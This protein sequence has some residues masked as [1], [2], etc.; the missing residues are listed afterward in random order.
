M[1][2]NQI[3][4]V[5]CD[6]LVLSLLGLTFFGLHKQ[7]PF[8]RGFFCDDQSL[9]HPYK[10]EKVSTFLCGVIWVLASLLII[11]P[12]EVSRNSSL[13]WLSV[14]PF[15]ADLYQVVGHMAL[16]GLVNL[17]V[18]EVAKMFVGRLRP[19]FLSLCHPDPDCPKD[20]FQTNTYFCQFSYYSNSNSNYTDSDL[21]FEEQVEDKLDE[22][23]SRMREARLSFMSGHA[24]SSFYTAIFL[25]LY[26]QVR[27][28]DLGAKGSEETSTGIGRIG[29]KA[30][31]PL[32]QVNQIQYKKSHHQRHQAFLLCLAFGV[33][34][35]RI[36]DYYHH[37]LDVAAGAFM[38]AFL[39]SITFYQS[40]LYSCP[41]IQEREISDT[42]VIPKR[43]L[44]KNIHLRMRSEVKAKN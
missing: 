20:V 44:T 42:K 31:K 30:F 25:I 40:K 12:T 11:L 17:L 28:G 29:L 7:D 32:L 35:T 22:T 24:A 14:K 23:M 3:Y 26:L 5:V 41:Q 43:Y 18:T 2:R 19:H 27:V 37:P 39:A 21:Q 1:S 10:E 16:G 6:V 8:Q 36:S 34:Y 38:G 13:C 15:A 4:R 9:K 33:S